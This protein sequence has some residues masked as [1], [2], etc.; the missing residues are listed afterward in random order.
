M[1]MDDKWML[2]ETPGLLMERCPALLLRGGTLGWV[3]WIT[4]HQVAGITAHNWQFSANPTHKISSKNAE[5]SFPWK[6]HLNDQF[7][8]S[9]FSLYNPGHALG[10][11]VCIPNMTFYIWELCRIRGPRV[12]TNSNSRIVR[13]GSVRSWSFLTHNERDAA[14]HSFSLI[15]CSSIIWYLSHLASQLQH[16]DRWTQNWK[17]EIY[18]NRVYNKKWQFKIAGTFKSITMYI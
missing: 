1:R 13:D 6:Y 8:T 3:K 16:S 9:N 17:Y 14:K 10:W 4:D 12:F 18:F 5:N 2:A 15:Y 11:K 7:Q